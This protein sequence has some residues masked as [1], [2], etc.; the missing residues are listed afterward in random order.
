M[1]CSPARLPPELGLTQGRLA[2]FVRTAGR[3]LAGI[4]FSDPAG[5]AGG[6]PT[7][8]SFP[9]REPAARTLSA[10]GQAHPEGA[11]QIVAGFRGHEFSSP[12]LVE[13]VDGVSIDCAPTAHDTARV[14][15]KGTQRQ[16]QSFVFILDCSE[17]MKDLVP[18][19]ALDGREMQRLEVAK[20][21]LQ[22]MLD[23]LS[24]Q[25]DVRVGVR[26]LG[27]R[28]GW[29]TTEPVRV[30]RQT[31][32]AHTIPPDLAPGEDVELV[33]PLG[34]F[35]SVAAGQVGELLKSV[36]AWGQ[37]PLY[38]SLV[39]AMNDFDPDDANT[40]KNIVVI[41]DGANYQFTPSASSP[42]AAPRPA[43]LEDVV[44]AWAKHKPAL[45][46]VG[47]GIPQRELAEAETS[48]RELVT[49]T[50][51]T[52]ETT[53]AEAQALLQKLDQILSDA[54]YTVVDPKGQAVGS[55]IEQDGSLRADTR[56]ARLGEPL[57]IRLPSA[58]GLQ[59][60]TVACQAAREKILLR[61]GESA[62]L[63]MTEEGRRIES[64]GY[65]AGSPRF[66][67]LVSSPHDLPAGVQ[68]G[69]HRPVAEDEGVRFTVSIQP[70]RRQ[71][72]PRPAEIW[73]EVTPLLK[74]G[75]SASPPYTFYDAIYQ[76]DVPVPVVQWLARKWPT[77]ALAARVCCW[78]KLESTPPDMVLPLAELPAAPSPRRSLKDF[79]G[80]EFQAETASTATEIV[81]RVVEW[82]ST[83]SAGVGSLKVALA[84][85]PESRAVPQRIIRIF[86]HEHR[87]A[88]H[89]FVLP[90]RESLELKGWQ[91][92]LTK[93]SVLQANALV[94][95]G[96]IEVSI[97]EN[98][99][100]LPP[101][102]TPAN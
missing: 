28:V 94:P 18:V 64:A 91:L 7:H 44:R 26:F 102:L 1:P 13:T 6:V 21:A 40:E 68:L 81:V 65:L 12:F 41:T 46:I 84:A 37:T 99:D 16:R 59:E 48:Y 95:A 89:M 85:P 88:A 73:V 98:Q 60:Y 96:P 58:P 86:D 25:R 101:L 62:T 30:L 4:V 42:F 70:E 93:A 27:H 56:P 11:L 22:G 36:R 52:F 66:A 31:G 33:L 20:N 78:C 75:T 63:L 35:D 83:A 100:L 71:F 23:Q 39:E 57:V 76:P 90:R 45:H 61:G 17:S 14:V 72:T 69:V 53:A 54:P 80:V 49:R 8:L 51:G 43:E 38:R 55:P 29:S 82:H 50:K 32:Y 79:A 19:E 97:T 10:G 3:R 34:R 77:Q 92:E 2:L 9:L 87:V 47:F 15:L 5:E 24:I 67:R 74:D